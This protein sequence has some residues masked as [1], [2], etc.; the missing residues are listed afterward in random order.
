[1]GIRSHVLEAPHDYVFG[2]E[3]GN[4]VS[5]CKAWVTALLL[6]HGKIRAD[7]VGRTAEGDQEALAAIDL[8]FRDLRRG[9]ASRWRDRG[10]QCARFKFCWGTAR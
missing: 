1:V 10:M 8:Q 9:C 7:G 5:Q 3:G 6:A 4:I 2:D